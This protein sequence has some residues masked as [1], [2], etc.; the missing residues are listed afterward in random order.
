MKSIQDGLNNPKRKGE[1][2]MV[3]TAK[4]KGKIV[5]AGYNFTTF[6]DV[7]K[8]SRPTLRNKLNGKADFKADE[9]E[10][11]CLTANISQAEMIAIFFP[12]YQ[13]KMDYT[14]VS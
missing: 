8:M 12:N 4:L 1:N 6:A 7:I 5:E 13:S 9:I 2:L 3:N 11:I 10:K 14:H